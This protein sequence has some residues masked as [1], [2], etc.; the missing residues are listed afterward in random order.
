MG[1]T[2]FTSIPIVDVSKLAAGGTGQRAVADEIGLACRES[3]FFY[4]VGHGVE[5]GLQDRLRDL[6]RAFFSRSLA[7]FNN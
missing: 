5:E 3:G 6:S 4:V 7:P 2:D 1:E